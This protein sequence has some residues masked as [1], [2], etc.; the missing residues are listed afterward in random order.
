MNF[1]NAISASIAG[2]LVLAGILFAYHEYSR[3]EQ[4]KEI[5]EILPKNTAILVSI[6]DLSRLNIILND[7]G[8]LACELAESKF[9]HRS[10]LPLLLK[11]DTNFFSASLLPGQIPIS[12]YL[13]LQ[14]N[15]GTFEQTLALSHLNKKEFKRWLKSLPDYE[16]ISGTNNN[17][18]TYR[19]KTDTTTFYLGYQGGF[20]LLSTSQ[21]SLNTFFSSDKEK[22]LSISDQEFLK[23]HSTANRNAVANIYLNHNHLIDVA[24][25]SGY[26]GNS[27]VLNNISDAGSWTE[28]DLT[29]TDTELFLNG[30]TLISQNRINEQSR[31]S[32][33][34][35]GSIP[36]SAISHIILSVQNESRI[37]EA[38]K[39]ERAE[40]KEKWLNQGFPDPEIEIMPLF[41]NEIAWVKLD[42]NT[43]TAGNEVMLLRLNSQ[44]DAENFVRKF[45]NRLILEKGFQNSD[46]VKEIQIDDATS[47]S[48]YRIP[49][50]ELAK[51]VGGV[52]FSNIN[53]EW[54]GLYQNTLFL[55]SDARVLSTYLQEILRRN[56]LG[57][58]NNYR[59]FAESIAEEFQSDYYLN[60]KKSGI[61][62]NN[63]FNNQLENLIHPESLEKFQALSLQTGVS[64]KEG[65]ISNDIVIRYNPGLVDKPQTIWEVGLDSV[66]CT[67]PAIV[68][69][70]STNNKEILVQDMSNKLY[71]ISTAGRIIWEKQLEGRIISKLIQVKPGRKNEGGFLFNTADQVHFIDQ[72]GNYRNRYPIYLAQKAS[73]GLTF[74]EGKQK[75]EAHFILGLEDQSVKIYKLDGNSSQD[76][77]FAGAEQKIN[78]E[79][80]PFTL[81]DKVFYA[82]HD[83]KRTYFIDERGKQ[84]FESVSTATPSANPLYWNDKSGTENKSV[85][86]TDVQGTLILQE[87]DGRMTQHNFRTFSE[88]HRFLLAD[89]NGDNRNDYIIA[90]D[91][92]LFAYDDKF[93]E[94]FQLKFESSISEMPVL[95]QFPGG[96]NRL[97]IVCEGSQKI[98]LIHED[99]SIHPGFPLKGI[100]SFS[101]SSLQKN[102][103]F[104]LLVGSSDGFLYQYEVK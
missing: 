53:T 31:N 80:L 70:R 49:M 11:A 78:Q 33:T 37:S 9:F 60:I 7:S 55:A 50:P 4:K 13:V 69:N 3:E 51:Y 8:T 30:F 35:L 73:S 88:S 103:N 97:G 34:L 46:L 6:N 66:L 15:N 36:S 52:R 23:L 42:E 14:I 67:K 5:A 79:I 71:L 28:W 96:K 93:R 94:L 10:L 56:S 27:S 87:I 64:Q 102:G 22:V 101:I 16:Q 86:F 18:D 92:N 63:L 43:G 68:T 77:K 21:V 62:L 24:N 40:L 19:L 1:R 72:E 90:D 38:D 82:F 48:L 76:W 83:G 2:I 100:S 95:Y 58:N 61:Y 17:F 41:D 26:K 75:M 39:K 20:S 12:A 85:V 25:V 89:L 98:Y 45:H 81:K 57:N 54:L 91:K 29:F 104:T 47:L 32:S 84:S 99:G 65:M 59:N 44:R 74:I